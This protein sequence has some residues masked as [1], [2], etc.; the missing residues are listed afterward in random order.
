MT[1]KDLCWKKK[2]VLPCEPEM[3]RDEY[4]KTNTR[5][6]PI[7]KIG[8]NKGYAM[9]IAETCG[10]EGNAPMCFRVLGDDRESLE[11]AVTALV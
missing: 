4:P 5:Q 11:M 10:K 8:T 3:S 2:K 9:M 1:G 7:D 6:L